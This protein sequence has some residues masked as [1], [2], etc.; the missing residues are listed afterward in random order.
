MLM[1]VWLYPFLRKEECFIFLQH[2]VSTHLNSEQAPPREAGD[3]SPPLF[4]F[5]FLCSTEIKRLFACLSFS[6]L[7]PFFFSFEPL[8]CG[9]QPTAT[10]GG[11]G[12]G[13]TSSLERLRVRSL[14]HPGVRAAL[15]GEN[16]PLEDTKLFF[17]L[18]AK[19]NRDEQRLLLPPRICKNQ[20]CPFKGFYEYHFTEV[21]PHR[22]FSVCFFCCLNFY[23]F[24]WNEH[25]WEHP[26]DPEQDAAVCFP[27]GAL[28]HPA[29]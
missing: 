2:I 17:S 10:G 14:T 22:M 26:D 3:A 7:Y 8:W 13:T 12:C 15:S 6:F 18:K 28:L 24:I 1:Y 19:A 9:W 25:E 5:Y 27:Q 21:L 16:S 23:L 11:L 4:L 29:G 20:S